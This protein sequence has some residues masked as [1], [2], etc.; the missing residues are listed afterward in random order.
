MRLVICLLLTLTLQ[1]VHAGAWAA[2][3]PAPGSQV[4]TDA[5]I[6]YYAQRGDTLMSIASRFTDSSAN[7]SAIGKR[8]Q[9]SKDISIP[10]GTAIVIPTALLPDEPAEARIV[11]FSG[12]VSLNAPQGKQA[13]LKRGEVLLEGTQIDTGNNGFIT[14]AMHDNS[15]VTVPSNSSV[16]LSRLRQS[17]TDF[18]A[19]TELNVLRGQAES[20]VRPL[21]KNGRFE[22]RTPVSVAGVRGTHF[23]VRAEGTKSA[24]EVLE[25][26]VG[27]DRPLR[28]DPTGVRAGYGSIATAK[29]IGQPIVLLPAPRFVPPNEGFDRMITPHIT[30]APMNAASA[31]HVQIATDA[32][33]Q[34]LI[35]EAR[36]RGPTLNLKD[37]ED[38][39]YFAFAS[40]IDRNGLEGLVGMQQIRISKNSTHSPAAVGA[41]RADGTAGKAITFRWPQATGMKFNF[42][43]ARDPSFSW[44]IHKQLTAEAQAQVP[45]PTFGTYYARV[46]V[47]A[48]NGATSR[49]SPVQPFTVTDQWVINEGDPATTKEARS[50]ASH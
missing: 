38:G 34:N 5:G 37:L 16:V 12:P 45:R 39:S 29:E 21:G 32:E 18:S 46:Q 14:L 43:V 26:E 30:L 3:T 17:R 48:P 33:G 40:A 22:V 10:I 35:S 13:A 9:I 50:V 27:I 25:G 49:F 4:V 31:Y 41:P 24:T 20:R 44:L 47:V 42:Q 7:W 36:T 2:G 8:N 1:G 19:R 11:A 15:R 28:R 23:R 6:T